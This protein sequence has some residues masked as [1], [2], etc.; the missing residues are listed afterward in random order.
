MKESTRVQLIN[1]SINQSNMRALSSQS[2]VYPLDATSQIMDSSILCHCSNGILS[3]S[4][5]W[6]RV[7]LVAFSCLNT[8]FFPSLFVRSFVPKLSM[9]L[10]YCCNEP[11]AERHAAL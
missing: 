10:F 8:I 5:A 7:L 2:S 9:M 11:R 1:Q 4:F 6:A 3:L